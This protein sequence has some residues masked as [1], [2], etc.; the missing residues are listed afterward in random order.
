MQSLE[1]GDLFNAG[2]RFYSLGPSIRWSIFTA[3]RIR[4]KIEVE[5]AREEQALALY[6]LAVLRALEDVENALV[7]HSEEQEKFRELS[8]SEAAQRRA[9]V[10]AE[11]QF[12]AGMGNF[13]NADL[14]GRDCLSVDPGAWRR[15]G[16]SIRRACPFVG[17]A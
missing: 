5:T 4:R 2:S 13:L 10:L 14:V 12:K 1:A 15:L 3:G 6:D 17:N 16:N 9:R 7:A 8:A 11:D